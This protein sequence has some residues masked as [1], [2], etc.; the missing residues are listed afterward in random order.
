MQAESKADLG[1]RQAFCTVFLGQTCEQDPALRQVM[2]NQMAL[3]QQTGAL[4]A[5]NGSLGT[6]VKE[7]EEQVLPCSNMAPIR[8][9]RSKHVA[10]A[11]MLC[12][13]SPSVAPWPP[14]SL[15]AD[16]GEFFRKLLAY[17]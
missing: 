3:R 7:L 16:P 11:G 9:H 13:S 6:Q 17:V 2:Q 15:A 8:P 1:S 12:Q 14:S 4:Q 10:V 5:E